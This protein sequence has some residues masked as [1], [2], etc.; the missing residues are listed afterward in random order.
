MEND[1]ARL[2]ATGG[3][4]VRRAVLRGQLPEGRQVPTPGQVLMSGYGSE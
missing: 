3:G 2:E 4:L 1:G